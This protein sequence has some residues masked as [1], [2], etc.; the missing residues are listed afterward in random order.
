MPDQTKSQE[1][2]RQE[3]FPVTT[4]KETKLNRLANDAASRAARREQ[5]YDQEH[6]IFTK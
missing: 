2:P 6:D 3:D 1:T 5:L 4:S